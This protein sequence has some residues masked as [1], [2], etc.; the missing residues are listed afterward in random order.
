M[1]SCG[2][3][4]PTVLI[5]GHRRRTTVNSANCAQRN[6]SQRPSPFI[7]RLRRTLAHSQRAKVRQRPMGVRFA[8]DAEW[9]QTECYYSGVYAAHCQQSQYIFVND[10]PSQSSL[11]DD[12]G[13]LR[14]SNVTALPIQCHESEI[15]ASQWVR[16]SL[17]VNEKLFCVLPDVRSLWLHEADRITTIRLCQRAPDATARLYNHERRLATYM[18]STTA[19]KSLYSK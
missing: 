9:L 5:R 8:H 17:R 6:I 12:R 7:W 13:F 18:R 16:C 2:D 10:S 15:C 11:T 3:A 14:C 19:Y 4:L 1:R